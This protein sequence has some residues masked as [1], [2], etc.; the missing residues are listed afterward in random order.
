MFA[1]LIQRVYT[2]DGSGGGH[3]VPGVMNQAVASLQWPASAENEDAFL[4][5]QE[6]WRWLLWLT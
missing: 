2:D 4:A 6:V 1:D 5:L 3:V